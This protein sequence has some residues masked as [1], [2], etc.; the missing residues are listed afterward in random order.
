MI[1][2]R[3]LSDNELLA[4]AKRLSK[5]HMQKEESEVPLV[6]DREIEAFIRHA[7]SRAGAEELI[8]PREI[9][10]DFLTLLNILRDNKDATFD[11]LMKNVRF[12]KME[13]N[14]KDEGAPLDAEKAKNKISLFDIDI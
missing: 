7:T 6:S 4:L 14:A 12:E 1:R 8:T 3:R 10:R 2:L 13:G 11:E 9:I 5:L